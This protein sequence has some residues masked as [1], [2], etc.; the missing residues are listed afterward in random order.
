MLTPDTLPRDGQ[1]TSVVRFSVR[2]SADKPI[3]GQR[4]TLTTTAGTLSASDQTTNANGDVVVQ[5][6][7][8]ALNSTATSARGRFARKI[9]R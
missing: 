7:A 1:S 9:N 8:P 4:L 3:A 6:T 2:D 5:F